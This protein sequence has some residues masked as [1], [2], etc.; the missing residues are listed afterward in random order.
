[1]ISSAKKKL[2]EKNLDFIVANSDRSIG[3]EKTTAYLINTSGVLTRLGNI[4]KRAAA[5]RIIDESI[6]I[7]KNNK[8]GKTCG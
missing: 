1:L 2:K 3:K 5:K 6:R 8:T 7:F 4:D